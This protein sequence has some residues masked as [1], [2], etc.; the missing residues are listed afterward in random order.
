M[1]AACA[2]DDDEAAFGRLSLF[3]E[4]G[5]ATLDCAAIDDLGALSMSIRDAAGVT[6]VAAQPISCGA[7]LPE[8]PA[9]TYTIRVEG[10]ED[11]L[12]YYGQTK[13]ELPAASVEL[14]LSPTQAYVQLAWTLSEASDCAAIRVELTQQGGQARNFSYGCAD[15]PQWLEGS[16]APAQARLRVSAEDDAGASF[17]RA[18]LDRV[19]LSGDNAL[20]AALLPLDVGLNV[21]WSFS[22]DEQSIRA[23][24]DAQVGVEELTATVRDDVGGLLAEQTI[25]CASARP[26]LLDARFSPGEQIELELRAEGE[27]RRFFGRASF[28]IGAST[29]AE[30]MSVE[31]CAAGTASLSVEAAESCAGAVSVTLRRGDAATVTR[32]ELEAGVTEAEVELCYGVYELSVE[33]AAGCS[34][35]TTREL[36]ATEQRWA[37][38]RLN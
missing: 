25:P 26:Y 37:P 27:A 12:R 3:T 1:F 29:Q 6:L 36:G 14:E 4:R 8:L 28:E 18:H 32:V 30:D 7:V 5:G 19:L 23:C 38:V 15:S 21:D 34:A 13:A 10:R 11:G 31:L 16:V 2:G 17:A 24:D 20:Q 33:S 22:V 35:T 9:A